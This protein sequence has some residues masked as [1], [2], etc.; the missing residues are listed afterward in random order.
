[1]DVLDRPDVV[2]H[3]VQVNYN[4]YGEYLFVTVSAQMGEDYQVLTFFGLGYHEHRERWVTQCWDFYT[5]ILKPQ[6]LSVM[7]HSEAMELIKDR[8]RYVHAQ[9]IPMQSKNA[10]LYDVL[11]DLAD[12]DAALA[13]LDDLGW[14][15]LGF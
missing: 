12:D 8:D 9:N 7:Q 4:A 6:K 15:L 10:Q 2:I 3:L 14:S 1:M 11:A 5:S 13:E